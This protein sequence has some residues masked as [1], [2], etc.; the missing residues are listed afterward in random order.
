MSSKLMIVLTMVLFA[1]LTRLLP[2][3]P[4]FTAVTAMSLFGASL[5]QPWWAA[6]LVPTCSL[7]LGD[8]LIELI[9]PTGILKGWIADGQGFHSGC[10]L[11]YTTVLL[12]TAMGFFLRK[13]V[14]P[15]RVASISCLGSLTFFLVTNFA[16]WASG[17]GLGYSFSFLGLFECYAMALPFF[18]Y[19]L[20][21]D[22]FYSTLLFGGF[23][24]IER[25]SLKRL[26]A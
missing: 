21:G 26:V 17:G 24:L 5:L 22:L 1:S 9:L 2:H 3:P 7:V 15:L 18:Q 25:S 8:L 13:N 11:I 14:T 6:L 23:A 16:V 10:F 4:N 19:S 12:I 20:L